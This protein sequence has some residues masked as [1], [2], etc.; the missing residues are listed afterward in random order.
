MRGGWAALLWDQR[1]T[2]VCSLSLFVYSQQLETALGNADG[3]S[4]AGALHLGYGQCRR[5]LSRFVQTRNRQP[6][7]IHSNTHTYIFTHI[8]IAICMMV[9]CALHR[10]RYIG[11][12][13]ATSNTINLS[14]SISNGGQER[15]N[16]YTHN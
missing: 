10:P 16:A 9:E 2:N 6:I 14:F 3:M 11:V 13:Y 7:P 15:D 1:P 5:L 8:A 4:G 12:L